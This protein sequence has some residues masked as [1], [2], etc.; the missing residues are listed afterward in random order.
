[1]AF[2]ILEAG[3][4]RRE[5]FA[6]KA[7]A[8][9]MGGAG[10]IGESYIKGDQLRKGQKKEDEALESQGYSVR[11]IKN[12]ELRKQIVANTSLEQREARKAQKETVE[13]IAPYEGALKTLNEMRNIGKGGNLGLGSGVKEF[14][15]SKTRQ[16]KAKYTTLGK[17]LI[18]FISDI[19]IRNKKEFEVMAHDIMDSSLSD[20]AREGVLSALEFRLQNAIKSLSPQAENIPQQS[21][22]QQKERPPLQSFMR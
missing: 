3:T 18:Q 12:P 6:S 11:G 19:P 16:D 1:M 15:S 2:R 14:F 10:D 17:S 8:A 20:A 9:L 13:K 7:G 5:S 22:P 21:A 4:P